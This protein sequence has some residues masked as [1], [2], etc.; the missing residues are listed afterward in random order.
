MRPG[1]IGDGN[2]S[3]QNTSSSILES[4]SEDNL[5]KVIS[6][7]R[8][9]SKSNDKSEQGLLSLNFEGNNVGDRGAEAISDYIKERNESGKNLKMINLNECSIGNEGF[10]KLK[11]ALLVRRTLT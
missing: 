8:I 7:N 1:T 10:G 2:E 9:T 5:H 3:L 11:E 6:P 4:A